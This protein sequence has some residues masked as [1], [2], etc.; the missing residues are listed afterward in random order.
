[1]DPP[2]AGS[3][4]RF[5]RSL[6]R[7]APAR[8]VYISC[9]PDTLAR[10][11]AILTKGGYKAELAQPVDMFPHTNHVE[12]VVT[13]SQHMSISKGENTNGIRNYTMR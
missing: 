4:E 3:D 1:M 8:V 7:L 5:L 2:R 11:L 10:D 6:I 13:L 12:T 9:N